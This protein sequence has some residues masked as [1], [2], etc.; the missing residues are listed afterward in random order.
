MI[1]R[2]PRAAYEKAYAMLGGAGA[3]H[4]GELDWETLSVYEYFQN[5]QVGRA[6]LQPAHSGRL[7]APQPRHPRR[8]AAQS[9]AAG[10]RTDPRA[11]RRTR[12]L[13]LADD[14]PSP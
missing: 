14:A 6:A 2:H 8:R 4:K 5:A 9:A 13:A 10:A 12:R 1:R 7:G 3:C 11:A